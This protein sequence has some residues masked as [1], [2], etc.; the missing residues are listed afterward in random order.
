M[1]V[2]VVAVPVAVPV[3]AVAVAVAELGVTA[4]RVLRAG[5]ELVVV[6]NFVPVRR[7]VPVLVLKVMPMA[8]APGAVFEQRLDELPVGAVELAGFGDV[9]GE[10]MR[11]TG[12]DDPLLER[13]LLAVAAVHAAVV[14]R[15]GALQL[16]R[17]IVQLRPEFG[18]GLLVAYKAGERDGEAQKREPT[19]DT[20]L[21]LRNASER[22]EEQQSGARQQDGIGEC[23]HERTRNLDYVQAQG[24]VQHV[25]AAITDQKPECGLVR[26]FF[27]NLHVTQEA[28]PELLRQIGQRRPVNAAEAG[29]TEEWY[30]QEGNKELENRHPLREVPHIQFLLL[31]VPLLVARG[32]RHRHVAEGVEA[33]GVPPHALVGV[34]QQNRRQRRDASPE[35]DQGSAA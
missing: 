29:Q 5:D 25:D 27:R 8:V 19:V 16:R 24:V 17:Q 1:D 26:A 7:L 14:G 33:H 12:E 9:D 31:E 11:G 35:H 15:D 30:E 4:V 28:S 6:M 13:L 18:V 2:P 3:A 10:T 32:H 34:R 23:V 20:E 21:L 22:R